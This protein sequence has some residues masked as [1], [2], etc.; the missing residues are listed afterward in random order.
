MQVNIARNK[1]LINVE[2]KLHAKKYRSDRCTHCGGTLKNE[3]D[4]TVCIMCS[5]K[6]DHA[7]SSC[8]YLPT[9]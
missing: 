5:R 9:K 4:M 1:I 6:S 8:S 7:C 2:S 3:F